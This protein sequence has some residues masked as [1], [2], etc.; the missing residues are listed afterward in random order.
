MLQRH[1]RINYSQAL[2]MMSHLESL[3][4]WEIQDDPGYGRVALM[5]PVAT[6]HRRPSI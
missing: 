1:F 4:F 2:R 6:V 3:K 5:Q